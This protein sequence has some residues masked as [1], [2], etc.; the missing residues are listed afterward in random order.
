MCRREEA[1]G[2]LPVSATWLPQSP[3][4]GELQP[5]VARASGRWVPGGGGR[6]PFAGALWLSQSLWSGDSRL[7]TSETEALGFQARLLCQ[8][9]LD[10]TLT[11]S[12][13]LYI[14]FFTGKPL[15][16]VSAHP[17]GTRAPPQRGWSSSGVRLFLSS[18]YT[19]SALILITS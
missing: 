7:Q 12:A 19:H 1:C 13:L 11:F 17:C 4:G 9:L 3:D 14:F 2:G 18:C 8:I 5:V 10:M 16:V 15:D 6:A